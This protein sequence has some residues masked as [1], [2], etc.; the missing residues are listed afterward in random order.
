MLLASLAVACLAWTAATPNAF[1]VDFNAPRQLEVPAGARPIWTPSRP[2]ASASSSSAQP[3][4]PSSA[5]F[6]SNASD[7]SPLANSGSSTVLRWRSRNETTN[8]SRSAVAWRSDDA[9]KNSNSPAT[10][11]APVRSVGFEGERD[12][13]ADPFGDR[14]A[15]VDLPAPGAPALEGPNDS[16]PQAD[17]SLPPLDESAPAPPTGFSAPADGGFQVPP[18]TREVLNGPS[19]G[20][21]ETLDD[22]DAPAPPGML[23]DEDAPSSSVEE[24][25]PDTRPGTTPYQPG[26]GFQP[27]QPDFGG[28]APSATDNLFPG[29]FGDAGIPSR[30]T[31]CDRMY[32]ENERNCCGDQDKCNQTR[33]LLRSNPITNVSLDITAP[34]QPDTDDQS[35]QHKA[36][37]EQFSRIPSRVWHDRDGNSVADGRL[38]DLRYRRAVISDND[39][40]VHEIPLRDLSDDDLCFLAAWWGVPTEC[41]LGDDKYASRTW[42]PI[43]FSWKA[44]G[45]CHKPLY[46]EEPQ[47][48]RYGHTTGPVLQPALSG[49]HFFLNVAVLPYKMGINPPNECQYALGYY[50]PGSCAPWLLP[51]VPIS[52]RGGLAEAGAVMGMMYLFP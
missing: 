38:T 24:L 16:A 44:S 1:G 5:R 12:P 45:L 42:T 26:S 14:L 51:P 8:T 28:D 4:A 18:I 23:L 34:F 46:F 17:S 22:E 40:S 33:A 20:S 47:L 31:D 43:T 6:V 49:A 11:A 36:R 9:W 13:F 32:G 37:L 35:A 21:A 3:A 39:G 50:R 30:Q 48:E 41:S 52:L 19:E 27:T 29:G 2:A 15:Q 7:R 25:L 10:S